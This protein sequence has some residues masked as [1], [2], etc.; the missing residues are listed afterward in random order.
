MFLHSSH[1]SFIVAGLEGR[2]QPVANKFKCGCKLPVDSLV[3]GCLQCFQ[4][5]SHNAAPQKQCAQG[6]L[7]AVVRHKFSRGQVFL[8][9]MPNP[10]CQLPCIALG[11]RGEETLHTRGAQGTYKDP[12]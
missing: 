3:S 5:K 8:L 9:M 1:A 4:D 6:I 2:Q 7:F 11:L 10:A 12:A